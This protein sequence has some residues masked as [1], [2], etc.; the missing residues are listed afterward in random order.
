ACV[1]VPRVST[2][3]RCPRRSQIYAG[4]RSILVTLARL[5]NSGEEWL[6]RANIPSAPL[7]FRTVAALLLNDRPRLGAALNEGRLERKRQAALRPSLTA[8]Q[9]TCV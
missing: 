2:F 3:T 7:L 1:L 5:V 4:D 8:D 6:P 9:R